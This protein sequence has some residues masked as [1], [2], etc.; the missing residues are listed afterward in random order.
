MTPRAA[1]PA[2][3]AAVLLLAGLTPA[4]PPKPDPYPF[5]LPPVALVDRL[6]KGAL[7]PVAPFAGDERALLGAVWAARSGP[8]PRPVAQADERAVRAHLL[9]SGVADPAARAKYVK[10]FDALVADAEK[11]TAAAET[12][13]DKA[14]RLLRFLHA[15]VMAKGYAADQTTLHGVFETGT[16]NCVSAASLYYLVGT[17]L[18]LDL[19]GIVIPGNFLAGHAAV[20]LIDGKKRVEVECT[21]PDG[22]DWAVKSKRPGVV[23]IG[24]A[25]DRKGGTDADGF[26]LA[27]AAA[28][29]RGIGFAKAEVPDP[30]AAVRCYAVA[31]ALHP[32]D[33][34]A[35]KNAVAVVA[36]QGVKLAAAGKYEEALAVYAAGLAAFGEAGKLDHNHKVIWSDYLDAEFAAGRHEAG[37]KLLPRA[38]AAVPAADDFK[39]PA[40]WVVRAAQTKVDKDGWAAGLA[41]ADAG[42]KHLTA[43]QVAAVKKWQDGVYRRRSQDLLDAGDVDG[44]FK[45]LAGRLAAEP[46]NAALLGGLAYH[47]QEALPALEKAKG[48]AAA[49]TH[50]K[51]VCDAFPKD[52][53]VRA[54][55]WSY[56]VRAVDQLADAKKFAE[57][58]AAAGTHAP[59]A[60]DK[61]DE[62]TARAYNAHARHLAKEKDWKAA[63]DVLAAG[64]KAVPKSGLLA[65]NGVATVDDWADAAMGRKDWVEAA[66]VYDI[67][68]TYFPGD[69]HLEHN[70]KVCLERAK[71]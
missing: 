52:K 7:G 16:Y 57:A 67:G 1:R 15:G 47:T 53:D 42:A 66:R 27:A 4:Q 30:A 70:K 9:A 6:A 40:T 14:D 60:G 3:L 61:A 35:R 23:V 33:P 20:D 46:T 50:F 21:N 44:S 31:L 17:R 24:L 45:L 59:F 19:T 25:P 43:A 71:K 12:A 64:R 11:A 65:T 2:A 69:A 13:G 41:V 58:V 34:A 63:L 10:A 49:A 5:P 68:L 37:L 55:G 26:G 62:L 48:L 18:G 28:V 36:N 39:I 38:A 32:A 56:A 29:N 54:M 51:A 8:K 22:Y